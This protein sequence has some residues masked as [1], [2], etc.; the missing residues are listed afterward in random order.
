[1]MCADGRVDR[2]GFS[3]R[4]GQ[5]AVVRFEDGR[6]V[7]FYGTPWHPCPGVRATHLLPTS[8]LSL[9]LTHREQ[10]AFVPLARS[11]HA[12]AHRRSTT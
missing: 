11:P 2:W 9:V 12:A 1:M 10:L 7:S 5:A 4:S 8:A 6:E 3:F